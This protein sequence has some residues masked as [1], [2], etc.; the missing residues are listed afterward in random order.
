MAE[1][2]DALGLEERAKGL[3]AKAHF[4]FKRF[5]ETFWDEE[6]G[7]YVLGLD[8][9]KKPIRS[10]T[11]N[12]GHLLWS[13][14]VPP[15]RAGRVVQRLMQPDMWSGWGIRTLSAKHPAFNPNS[16]HNGSVWPHD[17]SIIAMG[18]KRY[19][20]AAEA[21]LVARS[22]SA[23]AGFFALQRLPELFSGAKRESASFPVQYL[24]A[25]VPQA[26][27]AGAVFFLLNAIL[28]L[29]VDAPRDRLYL[30]P[31]LPEW[32]PDLVLSD[33]TVGESVFKIR[34]FRAC[35]KTEFEVLG[36]DPGKVHRGPRLSGPVGF[37]NEVMA[38]L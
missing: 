25:N 38:S 13:G 4:L 8:P 34:V 32:L 33:L 6:L 16:Y 17:N 23:A 22:L 19:G 24:G 21:A 1:V 5:N 15:E 3:R 37:A 20:F 9:E 30:S 18:F 36:G 12:G 14:I 7:F 35:G 26:W 10:V 11:S 29:E 2:Y 28:G 31:D 27:S